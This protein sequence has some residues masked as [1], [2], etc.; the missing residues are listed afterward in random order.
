MTTLAV[1]AATKYLDLGIA[2]YVLLAFG[3]NE[4]SMRHS[5][6]GGDFFRTT[7]P[8]LWGQPLGE[9]TGISSHSMLAARHMYEYGTTSRQL[10]AVAV[11]MRSWACLN[12]AAAMYGKP[13]TIE[14]HQNSEL[15]CWPYHLL[16]ACQQSDGGTAF[17][18]T[19]AERAKDL[20][21]R[22]V[23]IMGVGFGEHM[24]KL[25]WDKT[26][27]TRLDVETAK[28]DAFRL[29]GIELKDIDAAQFYDCFTAEVIFQLEDYGWCEKGE[30]GPFVE[31]GNIGPSGSTPVNTGGGMLSSHH[32]GDSTG[33]AEA[34][35]QLRG[36]GGKRQVK[37]AEICLVS[38]HG[39][40]ILM[41]GMCSVHSTL[42]LRR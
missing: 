33:L 10:G 29:A 40:E 38:G 19:A 8:G 30:G 11:A 6:R 16:D 2:K 22:P 23:Y 1:V 21:K 15:I 35:I 36:D 28:A 34:V 39:G 17:I 25:W 31:A 4:W 24:R 5:P 26:N 3:S 7:R 13:I 12:P 27:Y 41:P 20:K 37:N 14:D 42:I 32:H 9:L 18:V